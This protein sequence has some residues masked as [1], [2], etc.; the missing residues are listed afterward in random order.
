MDRN[1]YF[2]FRLESRRGSVTCDGQRKDQSPLFRKLSLFLHLFLP[3]FPASFLYSQNRVLF[4]F[5]VPSSENPKNDCSE[6][7]VNSF[8]C[9]NGTKYLS[10]PP[11]INSFFWFLKKCG[12]FA[13]N[14][15]LILWIRYQH[16]LSLSRTT[17]SFKP[18]NQSIR[19]LILNG[20]CIQCVETV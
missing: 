19:R 20:S 2:I 3:H 15:A 4:M 13:L 8:K 16:V 10:F 6:L 18:F 1:P 12:Y 14:G 17:F 7:H 11:R 5:L 9:K